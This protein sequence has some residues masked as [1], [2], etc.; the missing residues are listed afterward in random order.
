MIQ[1]SDTNFSKKRI[2]RNTGLLYGRMLLTVWFNLWATRLTLQNLGVDDLGVFG[3]IGSV[4]SMFAVFSNGITTAVQRF[5]TYELGRGIEG[6]VNRVFCT[7]LNVLLLLALAIVIILEP[8]GLWL[9]NHKLNIP[10]GS[11]SAAHWVFQFTVLASLFEIIAIPYNALV[12]AHEKMDAFAAISILKVLL[13]CAAAWSLSLF[14]SDRLVVYGALMAAI[15]ILIRLIYQVYCHRHFKEARYHFSIDKVKIGEISRFAGVSTLGGILYTISGEGI[16]LVINWTFG[17]AINAVYTI[18]LQLKN[19]ILSFALNL[20]KAIQPQITK[21]YAE[22]ALDV[23]RKLV[24]SGSKLEVYLI[25][26]LMLPFLCRT[27]QIMALWLGDVPDYAVAYA[28]GIVFISLTY[29]AF[30]PIRTA[31]LATGRIVRFILIPD[32]FTLLVLP[33]SYFVA[34]ATGSPSWMLVSIVGMEVFACIMR[35]W[36]GAKV[37][38]LRVREILVRIVLPA[39]MVALVDTVLCYLLSR[40]LPDSLWGLILLVLLNSLILVGII[41]AIG[42]NAEERKSIRSLRRKRG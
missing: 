24:Y 10:E 38:V 30:E 9:I 27:E 15:A 25:Y 40:L 17:V 21:T 33:L 1:T 18:A 23:H 20:F 39:A 12:I 11:L 8:C 41:F 3:V 32:S 4:V 26:F 14:D 2:V 5:I 31:V 42:L 22:G 28:Q 29:A 7:S 19:M 13:T 35:V 36:L 34:R 6:E 37:S 16:M